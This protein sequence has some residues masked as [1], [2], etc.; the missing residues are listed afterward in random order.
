M[1]DPADKNTQKPS[2]K[3]RLYAWWKGY[4]IADIEEILRQRQRAKNRP[5]E[6][7]PPLNEEERQSQWDEARVRVTQ[8]I[9]GQGFC[10]PGG[11]QNVIDMS[12]LLALSPKMSAM[13][14]GA[15]LGGPS[16]VLAQ[17]FGVWINGYECS[18]ILAREGMDISTA[19][20]LEK[21]APIQQCDLDNT[22]TFNRT[23]DRAFS[24][25][26]L[27][28]LQNK[29]A[30]FKTVFDQLK[31]DSLFLISDYF[32][33]DQDSLSLPDM[34]DWTSHEP[35]EPCPLTPETM[36]EALEGAGFTI[37]VKEDITAPYL[38]MINAAWGNTENQIKDLAA[39]EETRKNN[40]Q[41]LQKE[42]E[43][44]NRRSIAFRSGELILYRYLAHKSS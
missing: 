27:F 33:K 5:E 44:W 9:W 11:R 36:A 32:I 17:E 1:A 28:T 38:D 43:L 4:D 7:P 8:M 3:W 37:R 35:L 15:G 6:E 42:L 26:A 39:D 31:K 20:G 40:L 30:L 21:K 24:K 13:V 16:R 18:D 22:P 10:G 2:L 14:L 25:E 34:V 19:K 12:K 23:F 29:P 41:A